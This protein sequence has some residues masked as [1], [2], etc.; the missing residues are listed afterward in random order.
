MQ[1]PEYIHQSANFIDEEND[2]SCLKIHR[3]EIIRA[4]RNVFRRALALFSSLIEVFSTAVS[5]PNQGKSAQDRRVT[6]TSTR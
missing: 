6:S 3:V 1:R 2:Y 5:T 4:V